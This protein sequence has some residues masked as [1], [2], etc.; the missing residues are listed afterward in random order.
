MYKTRSTGYTSIMMNEETYSATIETGWSANEPLTV[1]RLIAELG[2]LDPNA[3]VSV[4]SGR[5]DS[6]TLTVN[7]S[8]NRPNKPGVVHIGTAKF[9]K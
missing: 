4:W 3:V 1:A 9:G 7:L 5:Y 2:K 8:P 6:E